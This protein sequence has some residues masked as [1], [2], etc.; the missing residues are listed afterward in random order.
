MHPFTLRM[1]VRATVFLKFFPTPFRSWAPIKSLTPFQSFIAT[2]GEDFFWSQI[3]EANPGEIAVVLGGFRGTSAIHLAQK[4]YQVFAFEP[5]P[6]FA[7]GIRELAEKHSYDIE[8]I[9]A[10][11]SDS[12]GEVGFVKSGESTGVASTSANRQALVQVSKVDFGAW[13]KSLGKEISVLEVNIEGSEYQVLPRMMETYCLE[14]V[15]RVMLQFHLI[16]NH[17]PRLRQQIRQGLSR[18]HSEMWC[19]D[20]VWEFWQR[21]PVSADHQI[22]SQ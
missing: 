2:G 17:A 3:P 4:G 18:T 10:A 15:G 22:R 16:D 5:I 19:F 11:A 12:E 20:W 21:K 13:V 8:V 6:E 14:Q 1:I 7:K 9:E